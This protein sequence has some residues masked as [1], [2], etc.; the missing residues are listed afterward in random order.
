M[1]ILITDHELVTWSGSKIVVR[2][3]AL[4]LQ[5][6]GH[7]VSVFST[8]LGDSAK[9]LRRLGI[10][11]S[12]DLRSPPDV[13]HGHHNIPTVMAMG[14]FQGVRGIWFCHSLQWTEIPP[15]SNRL[16]RYVA[17]DVPR[18][19]FL[20]KEHRIRPDRVEI[21]HNAVDLRRFPERADALPQKPKRALAFTKNATHIP[22]LRSACLRFGMSFDAIGRGAN[23]IVLEPEPFLRQSD[24]VFA[25]GRSAI[26]AICAG[27]AVIVGDSRGIGQM[28]TTRNLEAMRNINFGWQSMI[29]PIT[30]AAVEGE[31][32]RYD[33]AD[34]AAVTQRLRREADLEKA[35]DRLEKLYVDAVAFNVPDP[36]DGGVRHILDQW[37]VP[38]EH[39]RTWEPERQMLL[40]LAT[41]GHA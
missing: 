34:A 38:P 39:A 33:A 17:V 20:V 8:K 28:V 22:T 32:A 21:L 15:V 36:D 35:A 25:T 16:F 31:I 19:D 4:K 5:E 3:I 1:R 18:R 14:Q 7:D 2:D 11:V 9:T 6:R 13:I 30:G 41:R 10:R 26:E 24:I 37:P 27:A 29:R 12:R 23:Q 40:K